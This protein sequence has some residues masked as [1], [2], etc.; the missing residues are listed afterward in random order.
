MRIYQNDDGSVDK[1]HYDE[2]TGKM[3]VKKE[4]DVSKII[5][6]NIRQYNDADRHY[7]SDTMNH[8]ARIPVALAEQWCAQQGIKYQE[9]LTNPEILKRFLNDPDN[10]LCRTKPGKIA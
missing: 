5:E 3:H 9:F 6:Q 4:T 8:V 2:T 10:S 7:R 1:V